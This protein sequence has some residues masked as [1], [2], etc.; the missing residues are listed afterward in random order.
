MFQL[1]SSIVAK[2]TGAN[3]SHNKKFT[4]FYLSKYSIVFDNSNTDNITDLNKELLDSVGNDIISLIQND[5]QNKNITILPNTLETIT[6]EKL[7]LP[8]NL[9]ILSSDRLPESINRYHYQIQFK[10]V[11][12]N[13]S[14]SKIELVKENN[15][16]FHNP[17]IVIKIS[18]STNE[19]LVNCEMISTK[20][21]EKEFI[22]YQPAK[23]ICIP[24]QT[25]KITIQILNYLQ[26][27]IQE[28]L[29]DIFQLIQMKHLK[30]KNIQYS[31]FE[32]SEFNHNDFSINDIISI[33]NDEN[34][35]IYTSTIKI[36]KD[37]FLL[38]QDLNFD[39]QKNKKYTLM[40]MSLQHK[41]DFNYE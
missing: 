30:I 34:K 13:L 26:Q 14:L 28:N 36:I 41:I 1:I 32:L 33:F 38:T 22:S 12:Q 11:F 7:D 2:E 10:D 24:I 18:S 16:L 27:P 17:N 29:K 35:C 25:D 23:Q 21:L 37:I 19:Y 39:F 6:E 15:L 9:S 5:Y 4:Q 8:E 40:N 20:T 3:I 31:V